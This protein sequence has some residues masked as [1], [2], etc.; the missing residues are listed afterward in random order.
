VVLTSIWVQLASEP[1]LFALTHLYKQRDLKALAI[2]A[3]FL[4]GM[5]GRYL[6]V[7]IGAAATLGVGAGLRFG[8][9]MTWLVL[10]RRNDHGGPLVK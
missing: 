8:I 6:I 9:T 3:L 1:T 5:L 7:T 2:L 4:G 10:P